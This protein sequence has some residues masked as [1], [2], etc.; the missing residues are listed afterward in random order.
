MLR[1]CRAAGLALAMLV[2]PAAAADGPDIAAMDQ[3]ELERFTEL[4]NATMGQDLQRM[5][6]A[7]QS[8]DCPELRR[9]ANALALGYGY[10]GAAHDNLKARAGEAVLP[11][12][13]KVIQSRVLTFAGRVRAEDWLSTCRGVALPEALQNDSRYAWPDKVADVEFTRAAMDARDTADA[14]LAAALSARAG[15]KCPQVISAAQSLSLVAPYLERL[16]ADLM[17]RRLA[18]GPFASPLLLRQLRGRLLQVS[19]QLSREFG[20]ICATPAEPIPEPVP[21]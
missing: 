16:A 12:R 8:R 1:W 15:R 21:E 5:R 18:I 4:V 14:N 7:G 13:L 11:L 17:K 10:L 6:E 19:A 9:A 20:P 2:P 3:A